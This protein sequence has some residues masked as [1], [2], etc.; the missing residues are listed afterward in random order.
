VLADKLNLGIDKAAFNYDQT[1]AENGNMLGI[2][3][4]DE[5]KQALF[6]SSEK[7]AMA[8]VDAV[9]KGVKEGIGELLEVK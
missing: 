2:N 4:T 9:S 5:F 7:S 8:L 6:D 1:L 3:F